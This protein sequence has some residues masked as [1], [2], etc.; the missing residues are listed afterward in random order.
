MRADQ[1]G[2][3]GKGSRGLNAA[4]GPLAL[5]TIAE[6]AG[7][8]PGFRQAEAVFEALFA[9]SNLAH[10]FTLALQ[11]KGVQAAIIASP[12]GP[13]EVLVQVPAGDKEAAI[14]ILLRT[15]QDTR[16]SSRRKADPGTV[17]AA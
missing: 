7:D 2:Q 5:G 12:M 3:R 11:A 16:A 17:L 14:D 6:T 1:S 13:S 10:H 4:A 8:T 15:L 9:C